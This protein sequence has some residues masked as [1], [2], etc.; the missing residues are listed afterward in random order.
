MGDSMKDVVEAQ[1][2]TIAELRKQMV[3]QQA[4][5]SAQLAELAGRLP[6][7]EP[8]PPPPGTI[9]RFPLTV[10]KP[11][12]KKGQVDHPGVLQMV[13]KDE[14]ALAAAKADGWSEDP[15]EHDYSHLEE[16]APAPVA[17]RAAGGRRAAK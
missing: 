16:P 17:V 14:A 12:H 5:F 11:G 7:V 10:S 2:E 1:N 13:V 6:A 4:A 8:E 9:L 3:E 15:L